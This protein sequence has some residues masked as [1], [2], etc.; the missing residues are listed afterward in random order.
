MGSPNLIREHYGAL[1]FAARVA[2]G[3][4]GEVQVLVRPH[5]VF[6]ADAAIA[7]LGAMGPRIVVQRVRGDGEIAGPRG[8]GERDVREWVNTFRHADVVVNLSSTI[9]VDAAWFDRP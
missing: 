1:E 8:G 4:L 7:S 3:D 5:P 9:T 6:H 2:R